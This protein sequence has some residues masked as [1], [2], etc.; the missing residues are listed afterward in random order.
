[1]TTWTHLLGLPLAQAEK[2]LQDAGAAYTVVPT[3]APRREVR[4]APAA[5]PRMTVPTTLRVIRV[6]TASDAVE[7]VT[8]D[9]PDGDPRQA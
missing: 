3:A 4:G 6:Q 2:Y 1:M 9:F 7:L 5:E 8:G